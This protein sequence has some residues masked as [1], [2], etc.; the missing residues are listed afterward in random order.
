MKIVIVGGGAGGLELA[1]SLGRSLGRKGKAEVLLLDRAHTH[2]W[3]PLLHEVASGSLDAETEAVSFRAHAHYNS[4]NF[5]VGS[6]C[7]L[8]R[9][10]KVIHLSP[11]LDDGE[12]ILPQREEAYDYLVLAIGSV[13]NDFGIEGVADNCIFLDSISQAKTF[14]HHLLNRFIKLNRDLGRAELNRKLHVV[15]V[16]GGAT[17]VELSAE[18]F[19]ARQWFSTYGLRNVLPEHLQVSL[20]EAGPILLPAL[21]ERISSAVLTE[22]ER[23]GVSVHLSTMI[24][25]AEKNALITKDGTRFDA[26]LMVWAAGVKAPS[27]LCQFDGLETNN[28]NQ[29]LVNPTLLAK[30]SSSVF[31]IGDCAGCEM[32]AA[33]GKVHWVPPR[34]QSAHQMASTVAKN[35][36]NLQ[37]GKPLVTF[38]YNDYGSLISLSD[39]TA[40]GRLMGGLSTGSLKVEGRIARIAYVSLYRM[41]QIAIHGWFKTLLLTLS[42]KINRFIRPRLK[43][44]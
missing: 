28:A 42:D 34:A 15:I 16:G 21:S 30:N 2:V 37:A 24:T 12:E 17:G 4:F 22:L 25:R 31:A 18:L 5:K 13:S 11:L 40:F 3:K 26:D 9:K 27:F 43:L 6:I 8:D 33:D 36:Q 20:I 29:I 7:G 38:T 41:H 39:F 10:R 44:H 19:K 32:I 1:T 23:L 35:I 14:Q